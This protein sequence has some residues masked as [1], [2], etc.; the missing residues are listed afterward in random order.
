MQH[1]S[2]TSSLTPQS[3]RTCPWSASVGWSERPRQPLRALNPCHLA[4][5]S[6]QPQETAAM[7]LALGGPGSQNWEVAEAR[8]GP[9]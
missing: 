1:P 9:S 8:S 3:L 2:M 7:E 4:C 5:S 6:Q